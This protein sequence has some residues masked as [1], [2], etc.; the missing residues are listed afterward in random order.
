[1]PTEILP[2][3]TTVRL[4]AIVIEAAYAAYWLALIGT[5]AW[6]RLRARHTKP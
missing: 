3:S 2:L 6:H 4:T 5:A 1:M